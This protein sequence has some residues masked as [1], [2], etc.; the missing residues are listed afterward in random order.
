[1][2]QTTLHGPD[3]LHG[4]ADGRAWTRRRSSASLSLL[5]CIDGVLFE[6]VILHFVPRDDPVMAAF[7]QTT[8]GQNRICPNK[9]EFGQVILAKPHLARI[10]VSKF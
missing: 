4:P 7:G 2:D 8:F 10:S 6:M 1:M 3:D 5:P 9:S